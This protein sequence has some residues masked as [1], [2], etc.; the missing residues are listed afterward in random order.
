MELVKHQWSGNE[1]RVIPGIGVVNLVHT[2]GEDYFPVDFRLYAKQMDGKTKNEHF[3]DMLRDAVHDKGLQARTILFDSWY[4]SWE[5]LK[6]VHRLDRIFFSTL[7]SNRLVSAS[8]DEGYKHL[9]DIDWTDD[10]LQQGVMVKLKKVPFLVRLFKLVAPNGD[11]DWVI[12]NH[13]DASLQAD[14]IQDA[15]AIRWQVE[16]LHRELKQLTG[17]EKCCLALGLCTSRSE[18]IPIV[19]FTCKLCR[20]HVIQCT[21][22][23][24]SIVLVA[25]VFQKLLN[26][27]NS[28]KQIAM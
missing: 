15:N 5:N 17:I 14:D 3:R 27:S 7:Q 12:T 10:R 26:I 1:G 9:Q 4:A 22:R 18:K 19:I 23:T 28:V 24:I 16:Q 11:I 20:C 8:K 13:P 21:V 25:P 2:D 6:L